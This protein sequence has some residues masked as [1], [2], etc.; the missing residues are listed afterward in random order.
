M[1]LTRLGYACEQVIDPTSVGSSLV[2]IQYNAMPWDNPNPG[3]SQN[4]ILQRVGRYIGY[5]HKQARFI[6]NSRKKLHY[7]SCS[8]TPLSLGSWDHPIG[9][10]PLN[11]SVICVIYVLVVVTKI[12]SKSHMYVSLVPSSLMLVLILDRILLYNFNKFDDK[13]SLQLLQQEN[14]SLISLDLSYSA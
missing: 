6:N 7:Q 13:F 1:A 2:Q 4:R 11:Y 14:E 8:I 12:N 5:V 9:T 3:R 10:A